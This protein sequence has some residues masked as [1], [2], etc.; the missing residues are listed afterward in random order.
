MALAGRARVA[1]DGALMTPAPLKSEKLDLRRLTLVPSRISRNGSNQRSSDGAQTLESLLPL[2]GA[3]SPLRIQSHPAAD[4]QEGQNGKT[5]Q[6]H[7][8][9]LQ[10]TAVR[11]LCWVTAS[12][13]ETLKRVRQLSQ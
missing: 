6:P 11:V 10:A 12:L 4:D 1:E 3:V 8:D 2:L 7:N 5:G 9:L 13:L